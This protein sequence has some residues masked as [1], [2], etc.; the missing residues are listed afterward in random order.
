MCASVYVHQQVEESAKQVCSM[1]CASIYMR[2]PN[3][4]QSDPNC[5]MLDS[6][7]EEAS[8]NSCCFHDPALLLL[9]LEIHTASCLACMS[10]DAIPVVGRIPPPP[11][12]PFLA[13]SV[14]R[15]NTGRELKPRDT[16]SA[17]M[18]DCEARG[19][20]LGRTAYS[21]QVS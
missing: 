15:R 7:H 11:P 14:T 10:A 20:L 18:L 17:D 6:S 19:V 2:S 5:D 12:P 9:L 3:A 13:G 4:L 1:P 16:H 21:T 8:P